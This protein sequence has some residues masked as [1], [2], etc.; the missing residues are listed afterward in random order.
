M[1]DLVTRLA[2]AS[3]ARVRAARSRE[4][5]GRLLSRAL[6][7]PAP[8]AL[9]LRGG[10]F[11]LIAE[12]KRRTPSGVAFLAGARVEDAAARATRYAVSG[13]AAISVLTEPD[14]F[15]GTL[16]DLAGAAAAAAAP[17]LR[18]DFIV[19]PY[20]VLE[21]RADGAAGVL[22]ILRLLDAARLE[23]TLAAAR[24]VGLF[25]LLEAFDRPDL[26]RSALVVAASPP[27]VPILAGLNCRDL[28]TL[29][30]D[31]ARFAA[32]QAHLP[33]GVPAV[34]ESGIGTPREAA[35]VARLG[36]RA[37]LVGGAL[38]RAADPGA[39]VARMLAAGR[40]EARSCASA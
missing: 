14:A 12:F 37:A 31:P 13:A 28:V 22:L 32:L 10:R 9:D 16:A 23:A 11:D 4:P 36:Y 5:E 39:L 26:E 29:A 33:R 35:A 20:Q 19:D 2:Q 6:G 27:R 8:P 25:V 21:A 7:A 3:R 24:D 40:K 34:A 38:M 15:G 18:K 1:P 30:V 17:V